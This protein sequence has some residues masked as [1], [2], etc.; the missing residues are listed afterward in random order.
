LAAAS[1]SRFRVDEEFRAAGE[2]L[3]ATW[4]RQA[5]PGTYYWRCKM[6]A[7]HLPGQV[8]G[9]KTVDLAETTTGKII[10]PRQ[11]GAAIWQ[12]PGNATTGTIMRGMQTEGIRV[13]IEVDDSYMHAPDIGVHGG[14]Q[15][16]LD[17]SGQSD[18][19]SFAAHKKL[20][21]FV[22][23]IIVSTPALGELYGEINENIYVCPNSIDLEDWD[24]SQRQEDGILRIGWPGSHSHVVDAPLVR[25]ALAW[26]ARQKD[27]EV[28]VFGIGDIFPFTGP[29][30]KVP[31]TDNQ[32]EYRANLARC[33]VIICPLQETEWARYKSDVK[34]LEA[35]A[36]GAWPIVSTATAY[37]PWHERTLTCTTA[38]DWDEAIRWIV[39]HREELPRL[40]AEAQEYVLAER[41]IEKTIH[42]WRMAVGPTA[43]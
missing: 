34:A 43:R 24:T 17:R 32:D 28:W 14:W 15:I 1:A 10:F 23:G 4:W 35:V 19:F 27:V 11:K 2:E 36:A 39:R 18:R 29:V 12:F 40:K 6:Q 9:L 5:S 20:C 38:K 41:L 30:Q 31:W 22:D 3:L 8:L 37:T 21:E 16:E 33:D 13:L 26:A 25:R 7:K 42:T